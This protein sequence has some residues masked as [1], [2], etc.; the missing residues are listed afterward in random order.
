MLPGL[1]M[2]AL[3][4]WSDVWTFEVAEQRAGS[5][6]IAL[7]PLHWLVLLA[8]RELALGGTPPD[9]ERLARVTD[10]SEEA[11]RALF[12]DGP[13]LAWIAGL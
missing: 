12:P 4:S 1:R 3:L 7:R 6:G 9:L 2:G 13:T 8:A 10:L 5:V 11:L